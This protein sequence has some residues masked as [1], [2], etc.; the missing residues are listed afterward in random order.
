MKTLFVFFSCLILFATHAQEVTILD[1]STL[2]PIS[3]V[4][5][6]NSSKTKSLTSD[7]DGKVSLSNFNENEGITFHHI[8]HI[9]LT[10]VKSKVPGTVYLIMKSQG[11]DEIV[12]SASK[13]EQSRREVPQK[14]LSVKAKDIL[15]NNPQTSADLLQGIGSGSNWNQ[16]SKMVE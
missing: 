1:E 12:I 8:T 4:V 3:G 2:E 6:Y 15:F 13:F 9:R 5:V 16:S 14:I 11:L 7:L 10:F